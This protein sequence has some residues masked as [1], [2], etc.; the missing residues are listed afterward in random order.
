MDSPSLY[1]AIGFLT[2]LVTTFLMAY[3]RYKLHQN[4]DIIAYSLSP[5]S[6][7]S[8]LS[9]SSL[10][11]LVS[12]NW[13]HQVFPSFRGEDVRRGFLSHIQKEFER[14]GITLFIDND[15]DR[16]KSIGPELIEAI[17]RSKISVVL[18]SKNYASSTWCLNELVE[19]IKCRKELDQIVMIVFYE[20]D[21]SDVK[22]QSGEFGNVFEKTCQGKTVEDVARWREA[23]EEVAKIA[24]YDSRSWLVILI[25]SHVSKLMIL[26]L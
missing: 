10:P 26:R 14:K 3:K 13:R 21:P 8:S 1:P 24:G 23:L 5:S 18:I 15:I 17:R 19:I 4:K 9:H 20:V 7:S 12:R 11:S 6:L 16:S 22:K 2:L 25:P